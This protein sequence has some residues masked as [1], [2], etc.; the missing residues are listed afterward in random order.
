[1]RT[2]NIITA[3]YKRCGSTMTQNLYQY[4]YGQ[5][6]RL[7]GF[8]LPES[9]SVHFANSLM[10]CDAY[11]IPVEDE[12]VEIPDAL[13]TSGQPIFAWIYMHMGT[14]GGETVYTI[15]IPV[16][17][18]AAPSDIAPTPA[19][20]DAIDRA[21]DALGTA[22]ER[23]ESAADRAEESAQALE[24][25]VRFDTLQVLTDEQKAQ[26]RLNIGMDE[27]PE[28]GAPAIVVHPDSD[29]VTDA[30]AERPLVVEIEFTPKQTGSGTPSASNIRPFEN[31][32]SVSFD[33]SD[34]QFTIG[35]AVTLPF[36]MRGGKVI[37]NKDGP[38][39]VQNWW[40][41]GTYTG[42]TLTGEW[43]SDRDE[44][45]PGALPTIGASIVWKRSSPVLL[46]GLEMTLS[47]F[48]GYNKVTGEGCAALISEYVADTKTYVD[49]HDLGALR[50]DEAQALSEEEQ[51]QVVMNIGL[52]QLL[53]AVNALVTR[54]TELERQLATYN[55]RKLCDDTA[56]TSGYVRGVGFTWTGNYR[57][58]LNGQLQSGSATS[59]YFAYAE[60][61][62][63]SDIEAGK[64]YFIYFVSTGNEVYLRV[65]YW[66]PGSGGSLVQYNENY[67][68]CTPFFLSRNAVAFGLSLYVPSGSGYVSET[69]N[70]GLFSTAPSNIHLY[71]MIKALHPST[72]PNSGIIVTPVLG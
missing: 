61:L 9:Y 32:N 68:D 72:N 43:M 50:Y 58:V 44:Y 46:E 54:V 26:A 42:Q 57:C 23:S 29:T 6:L 60:N 70:V 31:W 47:A 14:E 39:T 64:T 40:N 27:L 1:M 12:L 24:G 48:G 17:K 22:V 21:I 52:E 69:V 28:Q 5:K 11:V 18:R 19:Q 45:A 20:I 7:S 67:K 37:I 2:T 56:P 65:S 10:D 59:D 3:A 51:A 63:T 38:I 55:A 13:L 16:S 36:P 71:N 66:V 33:H 53:P 41:S 4:D 35:Y 34:G 49:K 25:A 8:D 62:P 30:A 15:T